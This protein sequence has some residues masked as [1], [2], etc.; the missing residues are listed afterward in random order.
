MTARQTVVSLFVLLLLPLQFA[1]SG[2]R[3][4]R[5]AV[6]TKIQSYL[7]KNYS[8]WR[9]SAT[10]NNCYAEFK[11]AVVFGDFDGDGRRDYVVKFI[12]NHKGYILAFVARG[13]DYR[14][15]IL[16]D[17]SEGELNITGLT[18][19]RKGA[20]MGNENGRTSRLPNDAPV[21]GTCESEACPYV[22]HNSKFSCG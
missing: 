22:Y 4:R 5:P 12:H 14:P 3:S 2:Q 9:Q 19:A 8:G 15:H 7:N 11:R 10:A 6:P 21:I 17:T 16:L 1:L 18:S 13:I 20:K